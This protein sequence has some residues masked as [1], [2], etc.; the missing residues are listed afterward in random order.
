[1]QIRYG[2]AND[3]LKPYFSATTFYKYS[4]ENYLQL[5]IHT[6]AGI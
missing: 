6:L 1:M 4:G 3:E 5:V 2:E